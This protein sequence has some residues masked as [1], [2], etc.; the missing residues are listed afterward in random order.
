MRFDLEDTSAPT[1][2]GLPS[3]RVRSWFIDGVNPEA[4]RPFS[5]GLPT[6]PEDFLTKLPTDTLAC[7]VRGHSGLVGFGRTLRLSAT[8]ADRFTRLSAAWRALAGTAEV[9]DPVQLPGSGL[10]GFSSLAFADDSRTASVIDVPTFLMGRRDGRVWLTQITYPDQDVSPLRLSDARLSPVRGARL[11]AG[12]VTAGKYRRI[13]GEVSA[14]LRAAADDPADDLLKVV[15]ARDT[16]VQADADIDLRA[17]LGR[18]NRAFPST[19][20]Y[21]VAGLVGA[22]PELL[23]GVQDGVVSSRVLAGTYRVQHD[24]ESELDAARKQLGAH[25]DSQEHRYAIHSLEQSL[26]PLS[27]DL[28]VDS[29]PHLLA[30]SNVIHLASDARGTL[31]TRVPA[32]GSA[33]AGGVRGGAGDPGPGAGPGTGGAADRPWALEV[34]AAVHPTAAVGGVPTDQATRVIRESE[35]ADRGRFA[36]PIGWV[37]GYG[38]GQL[39]IALRCG[40][41]EARDRIRLWAGAGIM[42][43]SDPESELAETWAKMKPMRQALGLE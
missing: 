32:A 11:S 13:V 40:Q 43:D 12:R 1:T 16:V 14:R 41:L 3:L 6:S 7:W 18:L 33:A 37:D 34:A 21:A 20:T 30:L 23:I 28:R 29:E 24:P 2:S 31:D 42:P 9:D 15:L 5:S 25:K 36:G 8:G 10:L 4:P 22:T 26:T 39:G 35:A 19:W 27:S 38:N 17:V